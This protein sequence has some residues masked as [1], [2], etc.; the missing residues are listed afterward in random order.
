MQTGDL[1]YYRSVIKNEIVK[2]VNMG[3]DNK[4]INKKHYFTSLAYYKY[5]IRT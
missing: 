4:I 2:K 3:C 5:N 1:L